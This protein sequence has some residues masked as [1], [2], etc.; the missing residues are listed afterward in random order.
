[1]ASLVGIRAPRLGSVRRPGNRR[2]KRL[3]EW[4]MKRFLLIASV[5]G[6]GI[7]ASIVDTNRE[8]PRPK[9]PRAWSAGPGSAG[10][11]SVD[12]RSGRAV[13]RSLRPRR[14]ECIRRVWVAS[15]GTRPPAATIDSTPIRSSSASGCWSIGT[16]CC[17]RISATTASRHGASSTIPPAASPAIRIVRPRVPTR[18]MASTGVRATTSC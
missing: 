13:Y 8:P 3:E 18:P 7:V 4:A 2:S 17:A 14:T 6:I 12:R 9:P 15:S 11:G 1:M 16:A 5:L 10:S